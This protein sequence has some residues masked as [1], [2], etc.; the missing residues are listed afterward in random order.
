MLKEAI[1]QNSF[2]NKGLPPISKSKASWLVNNNRIHDND[3]CGVIGLENDELIAYIHMFPDYLNTKEDEVTKVY[4][5]IDWWVASKYKNTILGPYIYNEALKLSGK[6]ALINGYAENVKDFYDKQP[7]KIISTKLRHTIF[8]SL[9][10]SMLIGKYNLLKKIKFFINLTDTI[11]GSSLRLLNKYK[12]QKKVKHIK[13][14]YFN[15]IDDKTWGLLEPHFKNDLILK[16]KEYL[17][18]QINSNQYLQTP[19]YKIPYSTRLAGSSKNICIH[20][21]VILFENSI[22][23][24]LSY[25]INHNEFNVKYFI[26]I[27][28]SHY[29]LC[30]DGLMEHLIKS[31]RN[32]IFTDDTKLSDAIT[33][34]YH[35]VYTH[36][37][38]KKGMAHHDIK[39]NFK[40][41]N[42]CNHDGHFY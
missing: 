11:T 14:H 6:Q 8:F 4:W 20:N 16:S 42:M 26:V 10:S 31:K 41:V 1:E 24:F 7:F 19:T 32:F 29:M 13:Y 25:V 37:V 34:R 30:V 9:D 2:W 27:E 15:Q 39:F 18:W 38:N 28:D 22:I 21:L 17:N 5:F 12:S 3:Y 35:T 36:K 33:K 23:G 40:N